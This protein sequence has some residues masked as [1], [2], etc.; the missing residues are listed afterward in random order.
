MENPPDRPQTID[1]LRFAADSAFAML[2]GMQLDVFSPMKDGPASAEQ[3]ATAIGTKTDRLRLLL[4][5]LVAA[6]LLIEK[7]GRFAN[8]A[9][10]N[11]F[12][13]KGSPSYIGNIHALL[14][15]RWVA[16][17]PKIAE[18]IRTGVPQAKVD[19]AKSSSQEL[20]TFLRRIN[21][22]TL[23]AAHALLQRYDFS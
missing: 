19:F 17:L 6:G 8:T 9:E 21:L 15:H 5:A 12:L 13:V 2:A 16:N 7:D 11:Q 1:K 3:I 4:W 10:A 22:L 20:E 18:S 14:S 23:T